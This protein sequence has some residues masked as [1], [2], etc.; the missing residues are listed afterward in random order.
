MNIS[1]SGAGQPFPFEAFFNQSGVRENAVPT[2]V[3]ATEVVYGGATGYRVTLSGTGLATDGANQPS[4]GTITRIVIAQNGVTQSTLSGLSWPFTAFEAALNQFAATGNATQL[5][6]LMGST[7]PLSVSLAAATSGL[8]ASDWFNTLANDGPAP[9]ELYG[10]DFADAVTGSRF[11]DFIGGRDGDDSLWFGGGPD[12]GFGGD[13]NDLMAGQDGWDQLWGGAG[14]DTVIGGIGNDILGGAAGDDV[15]D[16]GEGSDTLYAY[17]GNDLLD[18]GSGADEMW[19]GTGNDTILAG[20]GVDTV[21]AGTGDDLVFGGAGDDVLWGGSGND[22]LDGGLG[23]DVIWA[24]TGDDT[25]RGGDGD[26]T[27]GGGVGNDV[28]DG[29]G[30]NDIV[31]AFDGADTIFGG[32]GNDTLFAGR[33]GDVVNGGTGADELWGSDGRDTLTGGRGNDS[34]LGGGQGDLFRF[35]YSDFAGQAGATRDVSEGFVPGEDQIGI[36]GFADI[37]NFADLTLRDVTG[38]VEL[39]LTSAPLGQI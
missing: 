21:G 18:G 38:G 17:T 13:G 5:A 7:T 11:G 16:G 19:G 32:W 24:F 9:L 20:D 14:S 12:T 27:L 10:S 39:C 33:D 30:G 6:V 34:L 8:A 31:Y 23:A 22:L 4:A 28:V 3:S 35:T 26:D 37:E 29:G 36:Y 1:V 2:S 15:L 25:V